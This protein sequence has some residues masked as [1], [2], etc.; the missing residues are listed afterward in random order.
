MASRYAGD[1]GAE[2][3]PVALNLRSRC[4]PASGRRTCSSSPACCSATRLFGRGLFDPHR[5]RTR[6]RRS[7][8]SARFPA[9][10]TS[11]NDIMDR[12]SDRRHPLKAQPAD[13]VGR[14]AG[15]GGAGR[16]RR[17]RGG[18][19]RGVRP[20]SV[21]NFLLVSRVALVLQVLY[22]GPLKH[23]VIIDVLDDRDRVRAARGGRR[24]G[25]STSRSAT[26]C[27]CARSLLALFIA[28]A[29]RRHEIVLLADERDERTGRF[30]GEYSPLPA[31][32]DDRRRDRVDADRLHLL[33]DQP[34]DAGEV[35][36]AVARTDDSVSAVRHLS[37]SVS[38]PPARRRRQPRRHA[39]DR[40]PAAL[41]CVAL[42]AVAGGGDS[43]YSAR[44]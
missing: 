19:A 38:G 26:G 31:R 1:H 40:P 29:K 34:R 20:G 22:S 41:R 33:H 7:R 10:S 9:S 2:V 23:I 39:A 6:S 43:S 37:V 16:G 21:G 44:L 17:H 11:V 36:D 28:L 35:R 18:G 12:D 24:S 3:V 14:A 13:R 8:S 30:C 4:V 42:W 25:A 32:S 5:W 27:W 15:A